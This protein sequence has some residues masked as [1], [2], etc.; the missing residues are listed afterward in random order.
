VFAN[1][2]LFTSVGHG[3]A[4]NDIVTPNGSSG[5]PLP[6][7]LVNGQPYF[8]IADGFTADTFRIAA[9]Q[10]GTAITVTTEATVQF[11]RSGVLE[12][13]IINFSANR[14]GPISRPNPGQLMFPRLNYPSAGTLGSPGNPATVAS[15]SG[16]QFTLNL[17]ST[18]FKHEWSGGGSVT[19]NGGSSF[20][21]TSLT[22]EFGS[23]QTVIT[24]AGYTP[25]WATA[26]RSRGPASS[27]PPRASTS[28]RAASRSMPM[29]TRWPSAPA[30]RPATAC[31][32]FLE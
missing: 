27:A 14:L 5:N 23:G 22:Y 6:D 3:F 28:S 11:L 10:G 32:S 17:Q 19:V 1:T 16:V 13:D 7:E 9:T 4:I 31:S 24:A 2:S 21:I 12:V 25:R 29:A 8:V 30:T 18:T 26:S 20:Q 15:V